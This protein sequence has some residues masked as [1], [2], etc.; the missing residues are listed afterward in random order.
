M[1]DGTKTGLSKGVSERDDIKVGK[2]KKV[3][4]DLHWRCPCGTTNPY[5]AIIN[6]EGCGKE[7][8]E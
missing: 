7:R 2:E 4:L 8:K 6:C 1:A 3:F 5:P